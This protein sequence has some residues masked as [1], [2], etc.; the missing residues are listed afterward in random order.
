MD[1]EVELAC[2]SRDVPLVK[3]ILKECED[4]FN[5]ISTEQTTTKIQTKLTLNEH[6][7]LD[8]D[9]K[10]LLG[11]VVLSSLRGR[12]TCVNTL[13]ARLNYC[14]DDML[15]NIRQGLFSAQ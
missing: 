6:H 9:H 4:S 10:D 13:D 5:R 12:I 8:T 1:E 14:L 11:G 3:S 7:N 15:P 2:L